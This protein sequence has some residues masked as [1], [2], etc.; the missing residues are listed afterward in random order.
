[1]GFGN[2]AKLDSEILDKIRELVKD[3]QNNWDRWKW[4]KGDAEYTIAIICKAYNDLT[5]Q[6]SKEKANVIING[7]GRL[8]ERVFQKLQG[9][10]DWWKQ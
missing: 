7:H 2:R 6:S 8:A 5:F 1:M 10:T 9:E 3:A 4:R